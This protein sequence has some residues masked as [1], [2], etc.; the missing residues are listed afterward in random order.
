MAT[1]TEV[2]HAVRSGLAQL[3]IVP[4]E[5]SSG[6]TIT[7]TVDLIIEQAGKIFVAEELALDVRLALLGRRPV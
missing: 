5:N 1:I 6:G 3:G 7:E 2:F 4:I